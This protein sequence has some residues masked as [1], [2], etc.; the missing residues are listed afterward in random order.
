[1]TSAKQFRRHPQGSD[2]GFSL[3]ALGH[4]P[5]I[6]LPEIEGKP[7]SLE[8]L[9]LHVSPCSLLPC[10]PNMSTS[11]LRSTSPNPA[12]SARSLPSHK[13]PH[14]DTPP[15]TT[16]STS[17]CSLPAPKAPI[18]TPCLSSSVSGFWPPSMCPTA[19]SVATHSS[20]AL[21]SNLQLLIC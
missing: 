20:K 3:P 19:V 5:P 15:I 1:M 4:R 11:H 18:Q 8:P 7:F 14:T 16:T 17:H 12:R 10:V 21:L 9:L 2:G 6:L 13:P